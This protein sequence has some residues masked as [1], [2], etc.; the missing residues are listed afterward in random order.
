MVKSVN[1]SGFWGP[2]DGCSF[3]AES[4]C[5]R[6]LLSSKVVSKFA[7]VQTAMTWYITVFVHRQCHSL[8]IGLGGR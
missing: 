8:T 1:H 5:K 6:S 3:L 4:E 7:G 2:R